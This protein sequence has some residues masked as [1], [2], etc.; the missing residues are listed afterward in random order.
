[1]EYKCIG[2]KKNFFCWI[3]HF[4]DL[5][6]DDIQQVR[7]QS[8]SLKTVQGP[9]NLIWALNVFT[10]FGLYSTPQGV[11]FPPNKVKTILFF[12]RFYYVVKGS[13][14]FIRNL[15][16]HFKMDLLFG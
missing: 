7:R 3:S 11:L 16:L 8:I 2:S 10:T 6:K 13:Y 14:Y 9:L 12:Y 15:T 5:K 1:M 4:S